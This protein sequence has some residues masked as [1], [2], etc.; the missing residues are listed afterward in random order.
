MNLTILQIYDITLLKRVAG[1][2]GWLKEVQK[3]ILLLDIVR[4]KTKR[5]VYKLC[6]L[7]GKFVF[8]RN[9]GLAILKLPY[10]YTRVEQISKWMVN[11]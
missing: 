5:V 11:G 9:R 1:K 10:M 4:L 6:T 7:V 8:C 3:T 2:S